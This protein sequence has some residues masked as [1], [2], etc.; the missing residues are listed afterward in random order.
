VQV[1]HEDGG[2]KHTRT[3]DRV[4]LSKPL[5]AAHPVERE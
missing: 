1:D 2:V 4:G 3:L 5:D